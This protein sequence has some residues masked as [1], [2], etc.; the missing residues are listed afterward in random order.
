MQGKCLK[1]R[2][3]GEGGVPGPKGGEEKGGGPRPAG[4]LL[5]PPSGRGSSTD[6]LTPGPPRSRWGSG[7]RP[8]PIRGPPYLPGSGPGARQ[9]PVPG[10]V[11]NELPAYLHVL[12][13]HKMSPRDGIRPISLRFLPLP[14]L[15]APHP[16]AHRPKLLIH[17][18]PAPP[19]SVKYSLRPCPGWSPEG[20]GE[21]KIMTGAGGGV[22]CK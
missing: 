17:L 7:Q 11:L 6:T 12:I 14:P 2:G 18:P 21:R 22:G 1:E 15:T 4:T 20:E 3:P 5:A 10:R 13:N 16:H 8:G 9:G 19:V